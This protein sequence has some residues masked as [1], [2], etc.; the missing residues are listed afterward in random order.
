MPVNSASRATI[1]SQRVNAPGVETPT[2]GVTTTKSVTYDVTYA[3]CKNIMLSTPGVN[4][5]G[6]ALSIC[7]YQGVNVG[8]AAVTLT[9]TNVD[10]STTPKGING[11][12][13]VWVGGQNQYKFV[14]STKGLA[15]GSHTLYFSVAGDPVVHSVVFKV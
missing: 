3:I 1:S 10:G 11:N 13:F 5:V 2:G 6:V 8:S 4:Q 12:L 14:F 9:P 15:K 7:T